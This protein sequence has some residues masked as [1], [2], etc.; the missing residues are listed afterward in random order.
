MAIKY[1]ADA[2]M[3]SDP[4][5]F[6]TTSVSI[7]W[8]STPGTVV[9]S[10]NISYS[11]ADNTCFTDSGKMNVVVETLNYT[12]QE[13]Q[14]HTQYMVTVAALYQDHV[15]GTDN[16]LITTKPVGTWFENVLIFYFGFLLFSSI[17]PSLFCDGD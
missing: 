2:V 9:H 3:L 12:F 6:G 15:I 4:V 17:C 10:Y 13:L 7:S 5:D 1:C 8:A 11:T 16:T 14:E